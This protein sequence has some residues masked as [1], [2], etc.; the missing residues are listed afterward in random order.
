MWKDSERLVDN[1][2]C[3]TLLIKWLSN[4]QRNGFDGNNRRMS[5]D[6]LE[7]ANINT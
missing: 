6:R 3:T 1:K 4:V 7:A 2:S 5:T